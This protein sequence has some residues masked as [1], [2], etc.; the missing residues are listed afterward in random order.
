[1]PGPG[2]SALWWREEVLLDKRSG[3]AVVA[4]DGVTEHRA[5]LINGVLGIDRGQVAIGVDP[6]VVEAEIDPQIPVGKRS[7]EIPATDMSE[8]LVS[9]EEQVVV[10]APCA[11]AAEDGRLRIS[12]EG[13]VEA[14]T[15]AAYLDTVAP[16][17]GRQRTRQI[18]T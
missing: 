3:T 8:Y 7:I 16:E 11:D 15:Q 4:C 1:M 14:G 2:G 12:A 5:E 18:L 17:Y 13:V 9:R 10:V 6:E